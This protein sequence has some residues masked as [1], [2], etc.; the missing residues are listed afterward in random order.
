MS[1][2]LNWDAAEAH[3]REVRKA[4][5]EIGA[6][7]IFGL[8]VVLDPLQVRYEKGERTAELYEAIFNTE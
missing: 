6:A 2:E 7:G 5:A 8:R 4:Y 1:S 3:L